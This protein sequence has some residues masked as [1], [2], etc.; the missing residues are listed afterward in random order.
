MKIAVTHPTGNR[1]VRAV[2]SSF[3]DA[4]VLAFFSTT[5][6]INPDHYLLKLLPERVSKELIRRSYPLSYGLIR[7]RPMLE[8]LRNVL[9]KLGFKNAVAHETGF[10]SVDKIYEDLDKATAAILNSENRKHK[11]DAVYC[12]EDGAVETFIAAKKLGMECL[13]DLPIGYWRSARNLLTAEKERWPEYASTLVGFRDSQRKLDRKDEELRLAERIFVASSFTAKT[14]NDYPGKLAP[15][16]VIPYGFPPV[17]EDREYSLAHNR[18]LKLL[19]VGGLSQR[20]GIADLFAA[21]KNIGDSVELTVVGM[22]MSVECPAL[23]VALKEHHWIPSR[24]HHEILELMRSHDVFVFPSLFEGFGLVIT[25]AMSQG[26]PVITTDRTAGPDLITHGKDG[27]IIE[28]GSTEALQKQIE[29]LITK[30][31]TIIAA[32]KA[33]MERAKQRPWEKYGQ[34]LTAAIRRAI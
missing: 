15:V 31:E 9:P 20:K 18:P 10:A 1:N 28:A 7:S 11:I 17:V 16:E 26:T 13:Y 8:V 12:Y 33:A 5:L 34:Q 32:G 25:E 30:P 14:L 2:M 24:S 3:Q 22:K 4:G 21:V 6:A 27:W 23:D 19:F 29:E